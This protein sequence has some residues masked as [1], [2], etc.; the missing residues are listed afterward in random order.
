MRCSVVR[1]VSDE[2]NNLLLVCL[3]FVRASWLS[4]SKCAEIRCSVGVC[5]QASI[6]CGGFLSQD[7]SQGQ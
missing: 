5:F 2:V 1:E 3:F 6:L 7:H 4:S